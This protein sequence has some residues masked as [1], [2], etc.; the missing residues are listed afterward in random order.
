MHIR[1]K[2]DSGE[3][4]YGT[5]NQFNTAGIGEVVCYFEDIGV[6]LEFVHDLEIEVKPGEW[7]KMHLAF[8]NRDIVA[9]NHNTEFDFL[10]SKAENEQGLK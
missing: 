5:S 6:E 9:N 3:Y 2:L 10:H 1:K 7:K 4:R 8:E